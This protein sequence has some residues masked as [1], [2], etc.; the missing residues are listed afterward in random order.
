MRKRGGGGGGRGRGGGGGGRERGGG[1]VSIEGWEC[2]AKSVATN[3]VAF[4]LMLLFRPSVHPRRY[5]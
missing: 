5:T 2:H 3:L 4:R 1:N